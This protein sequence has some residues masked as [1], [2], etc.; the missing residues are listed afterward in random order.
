MFG[1]DAQLP[2]CKKK[3]KGKATNFSLRGLRSTNKSTLI[4][5]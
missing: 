4:I 5:N 3:E 1:G 2:P